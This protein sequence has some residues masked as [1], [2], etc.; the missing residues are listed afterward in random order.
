M[1]ENSSETAK[2]MTVEEVA[3]TV[4]VAKKK[5]RKLITIKICNGNSQT[6]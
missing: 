1:N 5:S 6:D 4:T 2:A 3:M